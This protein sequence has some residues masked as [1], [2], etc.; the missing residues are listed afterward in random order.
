MKPK[1]KYWQTLEQIEKGW[2]IPSLNKYSCPRQE[3]EKE[4]DFDDLHRD[5]IVQEL[6][7]NRYVICGD[8]HQNLAIPVFNDGYLML[9]MKKWK[10]IMEEVYE[11][12][13]PDL[14]EMPNFYMKCL[15][16]I[17][18]NLPPV[19]TIHRWEDIPSISNDYGWIWTN[20]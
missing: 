18:E 13:N 14:T 4:A 10:E 7:K 1:I 16:N 12:C 5:A 9:S 17:E 3:Y 6:I 8:T 20:Q 19:S 2:I 11:I 15:C